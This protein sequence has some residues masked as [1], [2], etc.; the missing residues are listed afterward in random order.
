[1]D[2]DYSPCDIACCRDDETVP[3]INSEKMYGKMQSL[4]T[5]V[6]LD[7]GEHGGHGFGDGRFADTKGWMEKAVKFWEKVL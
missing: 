3:C 7:E 5:P 6:V 2:Q 1:M 4:G